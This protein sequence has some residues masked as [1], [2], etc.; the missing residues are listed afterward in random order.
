MSQY[1]LTKNQLI[2]SNIGR[3]L[4]DI[5]VNTPMKGLDAEGIARTNRMSTFGDTLTRFGAPWGPKNLSEVLKTSGIGE[6]EAAEFMQ[7]GNS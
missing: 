7:L 6:K 1:D 5:S 4:M 2:V 3:K